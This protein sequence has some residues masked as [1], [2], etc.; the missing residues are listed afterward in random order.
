MNLKARP[1]N[2]FTDGGNLVGDRY[3]V[4]VDA[5]HDDDWPFFRQ[6]RPLD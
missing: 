6:G 1:E 5:A 2:G 4:G 3:Q